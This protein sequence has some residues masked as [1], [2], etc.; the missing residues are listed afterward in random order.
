MPIKAGIIYEYYSKTAIG[1]IHNRNKDL[2]KMVDNVRL[3]KK[4]KYKGPC[5]HHFL[6]R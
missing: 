4:G 2:P 6:I 5:L 1:C 3:A